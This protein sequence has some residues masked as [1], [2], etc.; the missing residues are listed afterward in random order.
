M[1][2]QL[3]ILSFI[4]SLEIIVM[5]ILYKLVLYTMEVMR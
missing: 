3:G 5:F 2:K 1:K 4:L